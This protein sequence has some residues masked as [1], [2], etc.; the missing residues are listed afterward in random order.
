[1]SCLILLL[2]MEYFVSGNR[3]KVK[4]FSFVLK[5]HK[6]IPI[7]MFLSFLQEVGLRESRLNVRK[8]NSDPDLNLEKLDIDLNS[9]K[10]EFENFKKFDLDLNLEN[11]K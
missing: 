7:S 3:N 2:C 9:E 4:E 8:L 10:V 6:Q 1:M 5:H 11:C